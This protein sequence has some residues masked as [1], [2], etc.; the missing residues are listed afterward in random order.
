[1]S[2]QGQQNQQQQLNPQHQT[3]GGYHNQGFGSHQ[4]QGQAAQNA[5]K[6]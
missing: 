1:M 2:N 4:Q 5:Q 6:Q 3:L